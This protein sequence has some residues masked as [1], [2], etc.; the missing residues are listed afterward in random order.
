MDR[1][2]SRLALAFL[3][4]LVLVVSASDRLQAKE[5]AAQSAKPTQITVFW[6]KP[7][8]DN[9]LLRA[10]RAALDVTADGQK[11]G[12]VDVGKP[13]TVSLSAGSHKLRIGQGDLLGLKLTRSETLVNLPPGKISY[14]YIY[15]SIQGLRAHQ[16]DAATAEAEISG[17]PRKTAGT[18]TVYIYWQANLL[19]LSFLKS[20]FDFF[21]DGKKI[22][23][24]TSGDYIVAK[25]PAGRRIL[26]MDNGSPF[27]ESMK[28]ELILGAGMT[29]YYFMH[30]KQYNIDFY[31]LSPDQVG[32]LN[33]LRR[34]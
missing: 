20:D 2:G 34:R 21:V 1:P 12:E 7:A 18:A 4:G 5:K 13:L 15:N 27:S 11:V 33:T 9:G 22:G 25:V 23:T 6:P 10:L 3:L 32:E 8:F 30:K 24:M 16:V 14:F 17:T 29:H 31:E 19:E 28:Q 26:T